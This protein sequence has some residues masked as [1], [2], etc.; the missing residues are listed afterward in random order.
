MCT[1]QST[2]RKPSE[3]H[4]KSLSANLLGSYDSE[5]GVYGRIMLKLTVYKQCMM[6][7]IE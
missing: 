1:T 2:H 4:T 3:T 5:K 7:G 6:C